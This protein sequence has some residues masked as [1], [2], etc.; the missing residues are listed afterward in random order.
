MSILYTKLWR[1]NVVFFYI[2][3]VLA[4]RR[5]TA[6][7]S[8]VFGV[9]TAVLC[10]LEKLLKLVALKDDCSRWFLFSGGKTDDSGIHLHYT[11]RP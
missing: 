2:R 8:G 6:N 3:P 9:D 10:L 4:V 1:E 11:E 5:Y 7:Q